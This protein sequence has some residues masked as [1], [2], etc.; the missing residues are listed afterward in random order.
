MN[1]YGTQNWEELWEQLE[2][3]GNI[4]LDYVINP[5]LYPEI[6]QILAATPKSIVVDFGCG[7]NV[8]GIQL[9][10]G[11]QASVEALKRIQSLDEARFNT[12]LYLGVEGSEELVTQSNKYFADIGNPRNIATVLAHIDKDMAE[13][14][15]KDS[16]DVCTSRNF[17]MH[18]SNEA[19]EAHLQ[20]VSR[21]LKEGG[22][23]IF[24]TLNSKY[25]LKKAD[26]HMANGE[27]YEFSHGRKGEY[28]SFYH[29]YRPEKF[30]E[31]K[32]KEHFSILKKIDCFP[33]TDKYQKTHKRYYDK[34]TPIARVYVL[35][36]HK[37]TSKV[38]T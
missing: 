15:D 31:E 5:K 25:E 6:I 10:F 14:F 35:K 1:R 32:L 28:G 12:L 11:Y 38:Q 27:A 7:T 8:M 18:L 21:I 24:A 20:Y 3:D 29:Y 33:V 17:L 2:Q 22:K 4:G 34:D 13:I 9:L 16:I 36:V 19:F 26:R 23:Y 37:K 30:F